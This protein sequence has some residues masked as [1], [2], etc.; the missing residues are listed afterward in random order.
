MLALDDYD[1]EEDVALGKKDGG[2]RPILL[3][4]RIDYIIVRPGDTFEGLNKELRLLDHE[5]FKY[6]NLTPDS[7]L[8][9]GEILYL[10]PKRNRAEKG[11]DYHILKSDETLYEISQVYGVKLEKLYQKNNIEPGEKVK[12]GT[13]IY[14]R[15]RKGGGLFNFDNQEESIPEENEDFR[16]EF[17]N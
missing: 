6:N 11:K 16:F 12:P 9:A 2:T 15:K 14:L 5:L 1:P 4:N 17:D 8:E 7:T 10:Q 13:K 3:N